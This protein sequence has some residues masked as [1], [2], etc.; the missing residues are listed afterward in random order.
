MS[1]GDT[2]TSKVVD[3]LSYKLDVVG[4]V[5]GMVT[6]EM[7]THLVF[8][9]VSAAQCNS[10]AMHEELL[11]VNK[12]NAIAVRVPFSFPFTTPSVSGGHT[13][14]MKVF[15]KCSIKHDVCM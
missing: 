13:L 6:A 12:N 4:V 5:A 2:F 11:A 14:G 1:G 7:I 8:W 9:D 10:E 3:S 15:D